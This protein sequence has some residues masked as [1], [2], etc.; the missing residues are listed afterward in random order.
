MKKALFILVLGSALL[1]AG[2]ADVFAQGCGGMGG[3][4]MGGGMM[5]GGMMGGMGHGGMGGGMRGGMM[6]DDHPMWKHVM[7]LGLDDKQKDAIIEIKHRVMK[8]TIRKKADKQIANIELRD[9]LR[10][11]TVDMKAVEAALKKIETLKT[12]IR[13]SHIKAKEEIKSKLTPDQRKKLKEM[14]EMRHG[15]MMGGGMMGGG[16]MGGM[17]CGMMHGGGQGM[18]ETPAEKMEQMKH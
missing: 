10:K 1:I 4:M 8:D 13:L 17:G 14:M 2:S 11:D 15:G 6:D 12:E 3:G 7:A 5:G 16:M 9:L 18:K